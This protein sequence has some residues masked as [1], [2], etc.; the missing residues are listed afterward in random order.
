LNSR[1]CRR[2]FSRFRSGNYDLRDVKRKV[3][4][5][6]FDDNVL[7]SLLKQ[8]NRVTIME[9]AKF[10]Y[11]SHSTVHRHLKKLGKICKLETWMPHE[12]SE[13]NKM[14]RLNVCNFLYSRFIQSSFL[15]RVVTGE[16]KW[17]F[18]KNI[19]R[20]RHWVNAKE[21]PCIQ[22][23][24]SLNS[25]KILLSVWWDVNVMI[26]F[27]LLPVN[28]TI[29]SEIYCKHLES[30]NQALR[31]KRPQLIKGDRIILQHDN[32]RPHIAEM[33]RNKIRELGWEILPH[34]PYSPDLAPSDYHLFRSLEHFL[35]GKIFTSE[36]ELETNLWA[37]FESKPREFYR[38]GMEKLIERWHNVISNNGRYI[39]D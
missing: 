14:M 16:E 35:R 11:F 33:T 9:F 36:A 25:K 1:K 3:R 20:K 4:K 2:W 31:E 12:L 29:N 34:P 26:F 6:Q 21:S 23:E 30:L 15:D 17:I 7:L 24:P 13:N 38:R 27:N 19:K 18:Y 39:N 32:A 8:D 37:F 28:Q 22:V 5:V 10:L